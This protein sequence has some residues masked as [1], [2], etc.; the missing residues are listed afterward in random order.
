LDSRHATRVT[1]Q[2]RIR[3]LGVDLF[4]VLSGF[5]ITGILLDSKSQGSAGSYFGKF[6]MR[7]VL[8][9]F[10]LY[11]LSLLVL[12]FVLPMF[13]K[14]AAHEFGEARSQL[15]WYLSYAANYN[16]A[17]L[18]APLAHFWSLCIEEQFYLI[19]PLLVW[20]TPRRYLMTFCGALIILSLALRLLFWRLGVSID[21]L[22]FFSIT[23]MDAL[24]F[25][26]V[27]A[28][29]ARSQGGLDRS[30]RTSHRLLF[31]TGGAVVLNY[32]L[33]P[34]LARTP[35]TATI[36]FTMID[37]FFATLLVTV[38][39]AASGHWL[40][41]FFEMDVL[42]SFGKYSYAIYIFHVPF[43]AWLR[44]R[45]FPADAVPRVWG[46]QIPAVLLFGFA[47]ILISYAA[48]YCSWHLFEKHFLRL[49]DYFQQRTNAVPTDL[50]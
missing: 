44:N 37:G 20:L 2:A 48:A 4:F 36:G 39:T 26:A 22:Y 46:S 47:V 8:R 23:R 5:L 6:Y 40:R 29:L 41:G 32:L 9:I 10:P 27:V 7:R 1:I 31:I 3:Q 21:A 14:W 12:F 25:G 43:I 28:L 33:C 50:R 13:S 30:S 45:T 17:N 24:T 15:I 11:Y 49:K 34:G 18:P 19:W 42:R 38:L 16:R 35:L